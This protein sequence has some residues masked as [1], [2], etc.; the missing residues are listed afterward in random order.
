MSKIIRKR[1][2]RT[3]NPE[4]F[5]ECT[6]NTEVTTEV[7]LRRVD[8]DVDNIAASFTLDIETLIELRY[9]PSGVPNKKRDGLDQYDN[10]RDTHT[11][12]SLVPYQGTFGLY[13]NDD[14]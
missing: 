1:L 14:K 4:T 6:E 2:N 8:I 3:K 5:T 9:T 7:I 12:D 11:D 13:E 10:K